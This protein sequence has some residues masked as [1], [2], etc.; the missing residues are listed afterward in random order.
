LTLLQG[1]RRVFADPKP[2]P[3]REAEIKECLFSFGSIA[4]A[5]ANGRVHFSLPPILKRH[6]HRP[7]KVLP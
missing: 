4:Q 5:F 3:A 6:V 1:Q 2:G 7:E